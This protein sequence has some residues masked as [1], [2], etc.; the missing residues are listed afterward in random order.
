MKILAGRSNQILAKY[1]AVELN[2]KSI[3]AQITTFDDGEINIQIFEDLH[4]LEVLIVQSTCQPVNDRLI[5]LLLL[6]DATRRAGASRI[7]LIIPYFGYSRQDRQTYGSP[8]AA[9]LIASC[10]EHV[11]ANHLITIDLHSPQIAGFFNIPVQNLESF[12]LFAPTFE[13]YSNFIIVSPD[14]GSTIRSQKVQKQFSSEIA[15]INKVRDSHNNCQSIE[16]LGNVKGKHCILIDDIVD[17]GETICNGARLLINQGALSVDAFVTHPVLSLNAANYI[18]NSCISNIYVT[19]TIETSS[20][21]DKFTVIPVAQV[22][23][24]ALRKIL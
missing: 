15:I 12:S 23:L 21:P 9:R 7:I 17:S 22:V 2:I 11:G 18:Q 19:D 14:P 8:V 16:I 6:I 1:L 5:E 3:E 4:R 13:N 10:L 20:L 24:E